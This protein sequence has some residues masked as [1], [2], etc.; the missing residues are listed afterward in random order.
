MSPERPPQSR[1]IRVM[2]VLM[3]GIP[4]MALMLFVALRHPGTLIM[5]SH[6]LHG[7]AGVCTI[8]QSF[9]SL[10]IAIAQAQNADEILAASRII[11][12]DPRGFNHWSTPLGSYWMPAGSGN[13]LVYDLAEQA[14]N[15]YGSGATGVHAGDVVLD[16]GANVG[17]FT[18]KALAAGAKLV[19]SIEPAPENLECLRRNFAAEIGNGRVLIYPKGVWNKDDILNLTIDPKN[20]A[21]DTFVRQIGSTQTISVPLTTIDKLV[22]ELNLPKVDFIKMDIEGAE[23]KAVAGAKET[24]AKYK[25][26][27]ALCIYHLPEDPV[28]VPRLVTETVPAYHTN[29]ECLCGPDKIQPEVALFY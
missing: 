17:V 16:C 10:A 6:Y 28:A 15:I 9:D 4:A 23:T 3:F 22:R 25:P 12:Q 11:E 14:R 18:R 20:S 24:I 26:R 5:L 2:Q 8:S 1:I 27:M 19:V 13:A 21:Q 7:R 29:L